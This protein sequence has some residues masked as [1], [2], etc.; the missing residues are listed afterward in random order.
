MKKYDNRIV[1]V[2]R[3]TRLESVLKRQNTISQAR[4]FINSIGSN[5]DDYEEEQNNYSSS[6]SFVVRD[7]D[8]LGV[9]QV[10]DR[11]YLSNF[12]FAPNDIVVV[13]G[14][15]GL[16]ANTMKYL[17]KQCAIGINPDRARFDGVLLPFFPKDAAKIVEETI[18]NKRKKMDVSMAQARLKNGETLLAVN[19]FFIGQKTHTSARYTIRFNGAK[20]RQSSS[21]VIVSTGLG[22]SG[23]M[24][25]VSIGAA[26]IANGGAPIAKSAK[27]SEAPNFDWA[28]RELVFAVREPF[29]SNTTGTEIVFGRF[30]EENTLKIESHMGENGV[31]FSDGIE[32]DYLEFNYGMEAAISLA[33]KRGQMVI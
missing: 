27:K 12:V 13:V 23:W 2:K 22:M 15:D 6:L 33:Q 4:F 8:N 30:D 24:R 28:S 31:I 14:Q 17:D 19:D 3:A 29:P 32:S 5:F 18:K 21:G 1:V 11:A 20:E 7:L 10:L 16:V 26:T 25:S 9:V